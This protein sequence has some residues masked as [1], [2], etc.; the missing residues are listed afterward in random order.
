MRSISA[1]SLV[2]ASLSAASVSVSA[3]IGFHISTA[4][5]D[6]DPFYALDVDITCDGA[7]SPTCLFGDTVTIEG[8]VMAISAFDN[9]NITIKACLWG[10]CPADNIRS[11]GT[12]CDDWLTP[13][14]NQ[15]CG[16]AGMYNVTMTESIPEADIPDSWSWLVSVEIGIDDEECWAKGERQTATPYGVSYS[17]LGALI[18]TLFGISYAAKNS[19]SDDGED[20][21]TESPFIEMRDVCGNE[22]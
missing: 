14:E 19:C 16:E 1:I 15:T 21:D 2:A 3:D 4:T 18:G 17:M 7:N 11:A 20:E 13:I 6:G 12:L 9:E 5:C 22:V 8:D 10:Y